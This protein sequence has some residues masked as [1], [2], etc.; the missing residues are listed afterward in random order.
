MSGG[1]DSS[2]ALLLLKKQGFEPI[3]VSLKYAVWQHKKNLLKENVCCS[4]KSL[5]I[6]EKICRKFN[7]PH[8]VLD[9]S[10][11]FEKKIM[12]NFLNA[13]K[14]KKTP[15]PCLICNRNLKF[16]KLFEFAEKQGAKYIATGHYARKRKN[17]KTGQYELLR[18]KDKNKDQSYFLCLLPQEQLKR[19]IFPVGNYIK[20]EIYK[21]TEN[22]GFDFFS[23]IKQ[24]QDLCFVSGQSIPSYLKE[25]IGFK[26][27]LIYDQNGYVLGE[28]QGLHFYTIGQRKRVGLANGPWWVIGFDK[29]NNGL[30]V[31]HNPDD[32]ILYKKTAVLSDVHFISER[33]LKSIRV[34][35]KIRYAQDLAS[36]VLRFKK[37][38]GKN[39]AYSARLIFDIPQRAVTPGQWAVFYKN[40]ACLGGGL[41]KAAK[42]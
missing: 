17:Q 35:A 39:R 14:V 31:S 25:E 9:C 3:G 2:A 24:S 18:A 34:K 40:N 5:A 10:S 13:L 37:A 22:H 20:D 36:A 12:G 29:K 11:E 21:I 28:H 16:K 27:G 30:I 19:L 26:P 38:A 32:P 4:Q 42:S 8:Y 41:I 15:N 1:V 23:K 33:P 6:A 7:A